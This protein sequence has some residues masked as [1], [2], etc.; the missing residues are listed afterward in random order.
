M[1]VVASAGCGSWASSAGA[2]ASSWLVTLR[3]DM[4]SFQA[5]DPAKM[6]DSSP[7]GHA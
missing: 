5:P 6:G 4:R 1:P 3:E 2:D 7:L